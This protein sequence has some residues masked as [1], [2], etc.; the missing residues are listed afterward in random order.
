MTINEKIRYFGDRA[1]FRSSTSIAPPDWQRRVGDYF[2]ELNGSI[3]PEFAAR[4][5]TFISGDWSAVPPSL[6]GELAVKYSR[7]L[8]MHPDRWLEDAP[9]YY[10][11][12]LRRRTSN[13]VDWERVREVEAWQ[14][15]GRGLYLLG[16]S[17]SGKTTAAWALYAAQRNIDKMCQIISATDLARRLSRSAKDCEVDSELLE[18]DVLI[19]DDL[20]TENVTG[21]NAGPLHELFEIRV[22]NLRP[23]V[24]TSNLDGKALVV[25]YRETA[26]GE[27]IVRRIRDF[28]DLVVFRGPSAAESG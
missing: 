19:I 7:E 27:R 2:K 26:I 9:P 20:G 13:R 22:A 16:R 4:V 24:I 10:L 11:D 3:V 21:G 17:G 23:T 18:V 14:P 8:R 6:A 1:N 15:R 25:R 12:L 28:F 5:E